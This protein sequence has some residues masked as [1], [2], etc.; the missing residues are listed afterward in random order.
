MSRVDIRNGLIIIIISSLPFFYHFNLIYLSLFGLLTSLM[1]SYSLFTKMAFSIKTWKLIQVLSIIN[2]FIAFFFDQQSAYLSI[3][4]AIYGVTGVFSQNDVRKANLICVLNLIANTI[5]NFNHFHLG[6]LQILIIS[7]VCIIYLLV[8]SFIGFNRDVV[9]RW[10][11]KIILLTIIFTPLL[12]LFPSSLSN[13]D[14]SNT[15]EGKSKR[16]SRRTTSSSNV[17]LLN[18]NFISL[19]GIEKLKLLRDPV[20]E[21]SSESKNT[22]LYFKSQVYQQYFNGIWQADININQTLESNFNGWVNL[23]IANSTVS[24]TYLIQPI[25]PMKSFLQVDRTV[26]YKVPTLNVLSNNCYRP[27][28]DFIL[29]SYILKSSKIHLNEKRLKPVEEIMYLYVPKRI[30]KL[31]TRLIKAPTDN[32]SD[33]EKLEY[34]KDRLR[35]K[36]KYSLEI[37]GSGKEPLKDFFKS[38]QGWCT[39]FASA[40]VLLARNEGIPARVVSGYYKNI[41]R[42]INK[43]HLIRLDD[44]HAWAELWDEKLGW[45]VWDATPATES[46]LA[47]KNKPIEDFNTQVKKAINYFKIELKYLKPENRSMVFD[48]SIIMIVLLVLLFLIKGKKRHRVNKEGLSEN[49]FI[50]EDYYQLQGIWENIDNKLNS[51]DK[52]RNGESIKS[53][54]KRIAHKYPELNLMRIS[55]LHNAT[56]WGKQ[57]L[58]IKEK[59]WLKDEV[60][61]IQSDSNEMT[62]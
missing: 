53:H 31:L 10:Q 58:N 40:M 45:V 34:I 38:K 26:A 51:D 8:I 52:H 59:E 21:F 62:K 15:D 23:D 56:R 29:S 19:Q 39:H 37:K 48:I 24:T 9:F 12:F 46:I 42:N 60:N 14:F 35:K 3:Y 54:F 18:E 55:S 61:K 2:I 28:E 1:L 32:L 17:D 7:F 13:L 43:K 49:K 25:L 44:A 36:Y 41:N 47:N 33:N 30:R 16:T 5:H 20:F 57:N 50:S 27:T 11:F 6:H 22:N 4:F